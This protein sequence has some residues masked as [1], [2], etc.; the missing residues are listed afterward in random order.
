MS[1]GRLG[2]CPSALNRPRTDVAKDGRG[3]GGREAVVKAVAAAHLAEFLFLLGRERLAG[4]GARAVGIDLEADDAQV[5][6]P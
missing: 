2:D 4:T 1:V 5:G 6:R 3:D